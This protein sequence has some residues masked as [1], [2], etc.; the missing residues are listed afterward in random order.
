MGNCATGV[1]M[2]WRE[3]VISALRPSQFTGIAFGDWLRLLNVK[4]LAVHPSYWLRAGMITCASLHNSLLGWYEDRR[5]GPMV[6][7]VAVP[8]PL[9]VLGHWRQGTTYLHNILSIDDRFAYPNLFQVAF[10]HTFLTAER[11]FASALNQ[12]LPPTRPMDNVP[13]DMSE[14]AED[15]RALS[16]CTQ[17][18]PYMSFAFPADRDEY[19]RYLSFRGVSDDNLAR[20]KSSLGLFLKKLTWKY[21]R[22]LVLKSPPHTARVRMLVEM[23]PQAKFIHIH[24]NPYAV[25][26][27]TKR[28]LEIL[29]RDWGLQRPRVDADE[30]IL[31]RY[32]A[33]YEAFFE[34]R[35]LVP[36][37]HFHEICFEDLE[38]D[39]IRV[40]REIYGAL[41]LPDFGI[42]EPAFRQYVQ[43]WS[44]YTKNLHP[45]IA[46]P[47]RRTIAE[48]WH[49]SFEE[50]SYADNGE[51][52]A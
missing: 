39:P 31:R 50:W 1:Y 34:E 38:Q 23:F 18:S 12:L 20:W 24:R 11:V 22:P 4:P 46:K 35:A 40:V 26:A 49:R 27:S 6:R 48:E 43:S 42:V 7:N 32:A 29:L 10:P 19:D 15:E 25:F 13:V 8:P 17:L 36:P 33:M 45:E 44:G 3:A 51:S 41:S 5:F 16:I 9:F 52:R 14:P 21:G 37:G 30:W 47:L 28:H 2:S